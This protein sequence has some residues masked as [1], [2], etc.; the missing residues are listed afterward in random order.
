[1]IPAGLVAIGLSASVIVLILISRKREKA[2]KAT[3]GDSQK[4]GK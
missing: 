2:G 1:L 4:E 3:E